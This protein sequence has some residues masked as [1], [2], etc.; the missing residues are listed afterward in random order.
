[1]AVSPAPGSPLSYPADDQALFDA[2][3]KRP[4]VGI[5]F[6]IAHTTSKLVDG[7]CLLCGVF[8][9]E[10]GAAVGGVDVYDGRDTTGELIASQNVASGGSVNIGPHIPGVL[11]KRGV[12]LDVQTSTIKGGIW[13]QM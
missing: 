13:V 4:V 7:A 9:H 1:M 10:T 3:S 12:T 6:N 2:L 8:G 11:C 5:P